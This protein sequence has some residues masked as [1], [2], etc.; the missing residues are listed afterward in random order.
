MKAINYARFKLEG[1][2]TGSVKKKK[3]NFINVI[4]EKFTMSIR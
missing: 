2:A 1:K 4:E 3:N